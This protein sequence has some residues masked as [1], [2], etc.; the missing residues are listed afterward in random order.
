MS[1]CIFCSIASGEMS[2]E[3]LYQD[4]RY[5]VIKDVN[6]VSPFH[7]LIIPKEHIESMNELTDFGV[8]SEMMS[9]A[10]RIV[11]ENG[12]AEEGYRLVLNTGQE[13]GQSVL[14][15]HLHLLKILSHFL[16]FIN[17]GSHTDYF[18]FYLHQHAQ[19]SSSYT[20]YNT[21]NPSIFPL[22]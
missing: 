13:G 20:I 22:P 21:S 7:V 18:A 12:Y 3:I 17:L 2:S 11:R 4:A 6:P 15:L 19:N 1:E 16:A 9:I 8:I 10:V 14:H 5:I